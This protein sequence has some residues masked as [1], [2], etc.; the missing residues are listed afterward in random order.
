MQF[1]TLVRRACSISAYSASVNMCGIF[2]STPTMS[3]SLS[4]SQRLS[5]TSHRFTCFRQ[6][7]SM[8]GE[9][10]NIGRQIQ[11]TVQWN[12]CIS[13][14]VRNRT[15]TY[16]H[17]CFE[18]PILWPPRILTFPPGTLCILWYICLHLIGFEGLATLKKPSRVTGRISWFKMTHVS[19]NICAPIIRTWCGIESKSSDLWSKLRATIERGAPSRALPKPYEALCCTATPWPP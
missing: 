12:S 8:A 7:R 4:K 9:K 6:W 19:G 18:W 17:F 2:H 5:D 11:T 1:A 3:L 14:T 15:R 16:T 13:E 10:E